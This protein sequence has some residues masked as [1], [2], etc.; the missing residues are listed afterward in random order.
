MIKNI[1]MKTTKP[2]RLL[3]RNEV[4]IRSS[5][6]AMPCK[7]PLLIDLAELCSKSTTNS[8][9][10]FESSG[11]RPSA[12][13][14]SIPH[15]LHSAGDHHDFIEKLEPPCFRL[16]RRPNLILSPEPDRRELDFGRLG[17]SGKLEGGTAPCR[18]A[19]ASIRPD[20]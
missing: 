9:M 3:I 7:A 10:R 15:N 8:R 12:G 19:V 6:L 18:S 20:R 11:W 5:D 13:Y 4:N 14:S 1:G 17:K 16:K 2:Y